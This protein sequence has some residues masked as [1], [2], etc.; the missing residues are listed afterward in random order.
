[1]GKINIIKPKGMYELENCP[2]DYLYPLACQV[3][4][5]P[6]WNGYVFLDACYKGSKNY[7]SDQWR[8]VMM[9]EVK[10][11]NYVKC[12]EKEEE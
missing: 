10:V 6:Y 5:C 4:G 1:M 2:L 3:K 9:T 8:K 7:V 12:S 11:A